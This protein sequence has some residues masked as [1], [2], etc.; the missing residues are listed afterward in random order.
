M[1]GESIEDV[2]VLEEARNKAKYGTPSSE[3]THFFVI[4]S[5][6]P[7]GDTAYNVYEAHLRYLRYYISFVL[8]H[9]HL[10]HSL[11]LKGC[12][13]FLALFLT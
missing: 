6:I 4:L 5:L 7:L 10:A 11:C 8:L 3:T 12:R 2:I 9:T 1:K 13:F